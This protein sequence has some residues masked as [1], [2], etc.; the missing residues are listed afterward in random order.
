MTTQESEESKLFT[1]SALDTFLYDPARL[2]KANQRARQ[3]ASSWVTSQAAASVFAGIDPGWA[4]DTVRGRDCIPWRLPNTVLPHSGSAEAFLEMPELAWVGNLLSCMGVDRLEGNI[5]AMVSLWIT[6]AAG[7]GAAEAYQAEIRPGSFPIPRHFSRLEKFVQ[8]DS[9]WEMVDRIMEL[10]RAPAD[11]F[12]N[13]LRNQVAI[14]ILST[15]RFW[16]LAPILSVAIDTF[17][18]EQVRQPEI[19]YHKERVPPV[20][21]PALL[22]KDKDR[23]QGLSLTWTPAST[24]WKEL[25]NDLLKNA[26][27]TDSQHTLQQWLLKSPPRSYDKTRDAFVNW[28]AYYRSPEWYPLPP[29]FLFAANPRGPPAPIAPAAQPRAARSIPTRVPPPP[30]SYEGQ[31]QE[32]SSR[33]QAASAAIA[34][35]TRQRESIAEIRSS[36]PLPRTPDEAEQRRI[37]ALP[38]KR[39]PPKPSNWLSP[40]HSTARSQEEPAPPPPPAAPG[41]S[42]TAAPLLA[43]EMPAE[44]CPETCTTCLAHPR[45]GQDPWKCSIKKHPIGPRTPCLCAH[46][47]C[48]KECRDDTCAENCDH[49]VGHDA[50][51][52]CLCVKHAPQTAWRQEVARR[53]R[54]CVH[55]DAASISLASRQRAATRPKA[56]A[57]GRRA[58]TFQEVRHISTLH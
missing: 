15:V 37:A 52:P 17:W 21:L 26:R 34:L 4:P 19:G 55:P 22:Y 25:Q 24:W 3:R 45:K 51:M 33:V 5:R 42:V 7:P 1:A 28:D 44:P 41:P 6:D 46:H 48:P 12:G 47:K 30:N 23:V 36:F 49:R 50:A 53:A 43:I 20:I 27:L 8:G 31:E 32:R 38:A 10:A 54:E 2:T 56:N 14:T 58:T 13:S 57:H 35:Q 16:E 11:T 39:A 29:R 40:V 9:F 18:F